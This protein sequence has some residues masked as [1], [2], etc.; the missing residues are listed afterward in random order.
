MTNDGKQQPDE[1]EQQQQQPTLPLLYLPVELAEEISL[2]F[3]G[4]DAAKLLGVS[5]SFHSL[6]LPRVW[7]E[8]STFINIRGSKARRH[9]LEKYGHFVRSI[10]FVDDIVSEFKFDW[11]PFVKHAT[12]LKVSIDYETTTDMAE[13][14]MKLIKQSKMLQKLN[15]QFCKYNTPV[16]F[17][18]LAA[19]I[20]RLECLERTNCYFGHDS[21]ADVIGGEWR[22]A[23]GFVDLLYPSKRSKLRLKINLNTTSNE[24]IVR[25]LAPYIVKLRANGHYVCTAQLAHELFGIRGNDGQHLVFPQLKVLEMTSCC[26][27]REDYSV[28]SIAASRIPQLKQID[29]GTGSCALPDRNDRRINL[30]E[31]YN[32][33]PEYSGYAH[34]IVPSQRWHCL[35]VLTIGTVSSSILMDIIDLNPQLQRL[36]IG[37]EHSDVPNKN[38]ASRYNHDV[39]QLDTIMNRLPQ[40]VYFWIGRLNSRVVVNPAAIPLKRRYYIEINIG[41][42]MS[43]AP[44]A[45]AYILQ[46]PQLTELNFNEC[47]FVDIDETIQ[48]LQSSA[49]MCGITWF[50]WKQ[51]VW[52][53]DLAL[54]VTEKMPH[55]ER[56]IARKCPKKHRSA[57]EAKYQFE[58]KW[59]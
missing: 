23:A 1:P 55:L 28:E 48:L 13:M 51:I 27:N 45:A 24:V 40:L 33:K 7:V 31:T 57:F 35:T 38:D 17:D 49:A 22:R 16:K 54:A 41:C 58:V 10:N 36:T 50:D 46:M 19:A 53:Q 6:F 56:F 9:M 34:I 39:F 42:Q 21:G 14:L 11:L 59:W 4:R 3:E 47:I 29:F 26:F 5:R 32:W 20:N 18:K 37:L 30:H 12:H 25:E 8:L 43:I 15:L 2:F 44:S 52:N